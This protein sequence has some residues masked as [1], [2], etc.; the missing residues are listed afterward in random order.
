MKILE[1][2]LKCIDDHLEDDTFNVE[3]LCKE[4]GVS[5]RQ[6]QRKLKAKTNKSPIQLIS[7]VRLHR[8]KELLLQNKFNIAE[9]AYQTGFSSPSYFSKSFKREF[10]TSPSSLIQE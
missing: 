6:I 2:V 3:K 4:L 8:A 7:S 5:E 9:I 10:G 1:K